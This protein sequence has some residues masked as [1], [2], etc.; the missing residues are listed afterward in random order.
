MKPMELLNNARNFGK[1]NQAELMTIGAVFTMW[2][3]IY[4]AYKAGPKAEKILA[5]KKKDLR[6]VAPED[7]STKRTVL[8]ETIR[9]LTPIVS[10]P[11]MLG[12]FATGLTIGSHTV[13]SKKI[14]T[15]SAAYTMA[16]TALHEHKEK[17][18]EVLGEAK[19]QQVREAISKD[20]LKKAEPLKEENVQITGLGN[21]LCYDEYTDRYFYASAETIGKAVV[22]LSYDLQSEMWIDL[23]SFYQELNL[24][25]CKM[26][27]DLGWSI[28]HTDRGRIP[29]YYTAILTEDNRPCLCVQFDVDVKQQYEDRY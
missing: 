26:G 25:P 9:E 18:K 12:G 16:N 6:D 29:V 15:L 13:S 17:V 21:Q 8:W 4:T 1:R 7:K 20:H 3:A 2:G 27:E 22:K 28:E 19:A 23:N 5:E 24:R 10:V 11:I 14:A